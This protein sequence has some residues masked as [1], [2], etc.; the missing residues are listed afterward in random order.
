MNAVPM[1]R[2]DAPR[3]R[4]PGSRLARSERLGRR[5]R[6]PL[7][8][9]DGFAGVA[10]ADAELEPLADLHLVPRRRIAANF[11]ALAVVL[12]GV[13]MLSAVVLHTRLAERQRQI[14]QLE[15][16]VEVQHELFD[17]LRQ[18]RAVLRSP[19]RLASESNRL[20]MFA[21][22]ESQFVGVDP[23]TVAQI[24]AATGSTGVLDDLLVDG[25]ALDQVRRV[26]AAEA[27]Q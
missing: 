15:Q 24:I 3:R 5:S 23:W 12:L 1:R 8:R 11:A 16:Q 26:R 2:I 9:R 27:Q 6:H 4:P 21:P 13:L 22:P 20:G 10:E 14:D 19:T 18:Q 7:Q 17:V 25:D